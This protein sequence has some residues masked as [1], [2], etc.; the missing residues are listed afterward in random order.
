MKILIVD[1]SRAMQTI[2]RRGIEQLGYDDMEIRNANNGKEA[3]D[4]IR[5]W[6][7][8][9]VLCDWHMPEMT[10][11]ELLTALNRQMLSVQIGFVTT[12]TSETR[13]QEALAAGA[14]FFVQKP[15]DYKT[16]HEAVLPILQGSTEGEKALEDNQPLETTEEEPNHIA[17]PNADTLNKILTHFS[18]AELLVEPTEKMV[19]KE[20]NFPCLLG[21]FEDP[22][23]KKIRAVAIMDLN[24]TCVLGACVTAIPNTRV[25]EAI[26]SRAVP[27]T[28]LGNCN[29]HMAAFSTTLYDKHKLK[30]LNH[31]SINIM[32]RNVDT[33][34]KLLA[35]PDDERIDVE[36]AVEGYGSGNLTIIAS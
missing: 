1:D 9:L 18:K 23:T 6:E 33:I 27:K 10:G 29:K 14:K 20:Y 24:A 17:L 32:R 2:V 31:R 15:F 11:F 4:I 13:K 28:I 35:K 19:L 7:P 16:L 30:K 3:L 26:E 34:E 21:L 22:D 36:V 25:R 5:I 8:H 12:E